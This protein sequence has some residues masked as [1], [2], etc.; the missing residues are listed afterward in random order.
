[1]EHSLVDEA[2]LVS[3]LL[4]SGFEHLPILL[5]QRFQNLVPRKNVRELIEQIATLAFQLLGDVGIVVIQHI[6]NRC[7]LEILLD[8]SPVIRS[9]ANQ[10][11]H[12]LQVLLTTHLQVLVGEIK[13]MLSVL[14][15]SLNFS[16]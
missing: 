6:Q 15:Q 12:E 4:R 13:F 2:C 11:A 5:R 8:C 16:V 1:M 7:L 9:L 10:L 14:P 3:L